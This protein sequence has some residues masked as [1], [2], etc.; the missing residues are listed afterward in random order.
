MPRVMT[1][2]TEKTEQQKWMEKNHADKKTILG[3]GPSPAGK[4][5]KTRGYFQVLNIRLPLKI[6][7]LGIL[8]DGHNIR[9]KTLIN[10]GVFFTSVNFEAEG[11]C[12]DLR[13][14]V[15]AVEEKL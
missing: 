3:D 8:A 13:C 15:H 7:R 14:F 5:V 10:K 6:H 12:D 11:L 9:F 1:R 2:K 4:W